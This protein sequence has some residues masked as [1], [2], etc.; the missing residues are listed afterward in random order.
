MK[1]KIIRAVICASLMLLG[2]SSQGHP[3]AQ[4]Q[5]GTSELDQYTTNKLNGISNQNSAKRFSSNRFMNQA[6]RRSIPRYSQYSN[7]DIKQQI[8]GSTAT[9]RPKNKPFSSVSRGPAVTPYLGLSGLPTG[10]APNYYS[11]VKPQLEQQRV[12]QRNQRQ[13]RAM[14]HQLNQV[15]AQGPYSIKG[16][17][18]IAPTGHAAV[19][20]N[21]GGYYPGR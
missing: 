1:A 3:M 9:S 4:A 21:L 17:E 15:A 6:T 18:N 7:Q 10:G 14:Q 19:Y 13:A 8:F 20:L 12:N 5:S 2:I 16:S 11:N